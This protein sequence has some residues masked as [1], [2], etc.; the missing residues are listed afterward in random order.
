MQEA[1][2]Q[3]ALPGAVSTVDKYPRTTYEYGNHVHICVYSYSIVDVIKQR[4]M[5]NSGVKGTKEKN[6]RSRCIGKLL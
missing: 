5:V 3:L 6:L 1:G 2:K 4:N